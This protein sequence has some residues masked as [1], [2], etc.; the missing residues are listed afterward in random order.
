MVVV[1]VRHLPFG[2]TQQIFRRRRRRVSRSSSLR[3]GIDKIRSS[4]S[5]ACT[6]LRFSR[7]GNTFSCSCVGMVDSRSPLVHGGSADVIRLHG[8]TAVA[9]LTHTCSLKRLPVSRCT[10]GCSPVNPISPYRI[11]TI[12]LHH[13]LRRYPETHKR[14]G[15]RCSNM[16][17]YD[18]L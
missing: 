3:R 9:S 4:S 11:L 17:L 14:L 8:G 13:R 18:F 7:L 16:P 2:R 5:L 12:V 10:G 15:A 1:S 6:I